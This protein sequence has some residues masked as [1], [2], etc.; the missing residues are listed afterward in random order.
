MFPQISFLPTSAAEAPTQKSWAKT[1][2]STILTAG[3]QIEIYISQ[4]KPNQPEIGQ[5]SLLNRAALVD[6]KVDGL[7]VARKEIDK[8]AG[9]NGGSPVAS[10]NCSAVALMAFGQSVM[11]RQRA[12]AAHKIP[13]LRRRSFEPGLRRLAEL[14]TRAR[15]H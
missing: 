13:V 2:T 15:D 5:S 7:R 11:S 4:R 10:V 9:E 3:I 1:S 6:K 8:C 12:T 14:R